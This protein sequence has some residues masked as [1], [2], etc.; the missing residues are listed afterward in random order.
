MKEHEIIWKNTE[1]EFQYYDDEFEKWVSRISKIVLDVICALFFVAA[2]R[3]MLNDVYYWATFSFED[4]IEVFVLGTI[5]SAVVDLIN[6]VKLR[7]KLIVRGAVLGAALLFSFGNLFIWGNWQQI[8]VDLEKLYTLYIND[9]VVEIPDNYNAMLI[10]YSMEQYS[11]DPYILN[12]VTM[13]LFLILFSLAK[14]LRKNDIMLA[15]PILCLVL[16]IIRGYTPD[17]EGF[18][19]MIVGIALAKV[20][21]IS[22][23]HFTLAPGRKYIN[24]GSL[25][26]FWWVILVGCVILSGNIVKFGGTSAAK[27]L[28][29]YS[30]SVV[31]VCD[32]ILNKFTDT[33]GN[34]DEEKDY[35]RVRIDNDTPKYEHIT[36]LTISMD[37]MPMGQMYLKGYSANTY[38]NG[39]WKNNVDGLKKMSVDNDIEYEK[40]CENILNMGAETVKKAYGLK[41][42]KD[43]QI[44]NSIKIQY[45][46]DVGE[47]VHLPYFAEI[48]NPNIF[49]DD[50]IRYRKDRKTDVLSFASWDFE[51]VWLEKI[52]YLA[53]GDEYY[54]KY[55]LEEYTKIPDDMENVKKIAAQIKDK[56]IKEYGKTLDSDRLVNEKRIQLTYE[57]VKWLMNNTEYSL[58]LPNIPFGEDPIEFF[59]GESK[60]GYCMHYASAATLMLRELGVP[61]RYASGYSVLKEDFSKGVANYTA[62]VLDDSAH[63]WVE[64]YMEGYGWLPYEATKGFNT[65]LINYEDNDGNGGNVTGSNGSNDYGDIADEAGDNNDVE[66]TEDESEEKVENN[67]KKFDFKVIG[68]VCVVILLMAFIFIVIVLLINNYSNR[69]SKKLEREREKENALTVIKMIN[70]RM[71]NKLLLSGKIRKLAIRDD[72]YREALIYNYCEIPESDWDKYMEIVKAAA[73]SK[74]E[75]TVEEMEFCIDIYLKVS[76][77][78]KKS[79]E[80]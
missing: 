62:F 44:G 56:Y 69:F 26:F 30:D 77:K 34:F 72:E 54:S 11:I 71:Y 52:D 3:V 31:R 74:R 66:N 68:I 61:A 9:A 42:L 12:L 36:V 57:V 19:F 22:K 7:D 25:R 63:A 28:L 29:K 27:G 4:L 79:M 39:V 67:K 50:D 49:I 23:V 45:M 48:N 46:E 15:F 8:S 38:S 65:G 33:M 32:Q 24:V 60:K 55:V 6:P 2:G 20:Y 5:I 37:S 51:A 80:S 64:I 18:L 13:I 58:N 43:A 47:K 76:V 75:F 53:T 14:T 40:L 59:I 35:E 78:P 41:S 21:S 1:G 70:G 73:F 17:Y 16:E 10:Y